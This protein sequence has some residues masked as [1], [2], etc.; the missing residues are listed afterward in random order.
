MVNAVQFNSIMH[1]KGS[2]ELLSTAVYYD[3][4]AHASTHWYHHGCDE[5]PIHE[6]FI[7]TANFIRQIYICFVGD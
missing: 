3:I 6:K 5:R 7:P 4:V 1:S 2:S